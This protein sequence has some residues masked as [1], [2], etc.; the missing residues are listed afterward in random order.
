[1]GPRCGPGTCGT[2]LHRRAARQP[3]M[4]RGPGQG[5]QVVASS[6]PR[7]RRGAD[8]GTPPL[9]RQLVAAALIL[10]RSSMARWLLFE[11]A[12]PRGSSRHLASV[13]DPYPRVAI[14]GRSEGTR[15]DRAGGGSDS[16][17]RTS[18]A[19]SGQQLKRCRIRT[20]DDRGSRRRPRAAEGVVHRGPIARCAA[21]ACRLS[22]GDVLGSGR[23]RRAR[24][25]SVDVEAR[26]SGRSAAVSSA[27]RSAQR[28]IRLS[29]PQLVAFVG[30]GN[31]PNFS[32]R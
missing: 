29:R 20:R 15:P 19:R 31:E 7:R 10:T 30:V 14:G 1:M 11:P 21:R 24:T 27:S 3:L 9:A 32:M 26:V 4:F 16:R 23:S 17:A 22:R 12:E 5:A 25:A 13:R 6:G 2:L 18:P 8:G 28:N